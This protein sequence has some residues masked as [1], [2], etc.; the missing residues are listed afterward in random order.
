MSDEFRLLGYDAATGRTAY[1]VTEPG[2]FLEAM[3]DVTALETATVWH[4]LA[5]TMAEGRSL[6]ADEA[7]F[8]LAHV[9]EAL[10][11]VLPIAMR[12]VD[13][14]GSA[15]R[16]AETGRGTGSAVHDMKP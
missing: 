16:C 10:G 12:A 13:T 15:A 8:V 3:A 9:V 7:N 5:G 6:C 14:D 2:G 11:A 4:T 1:A